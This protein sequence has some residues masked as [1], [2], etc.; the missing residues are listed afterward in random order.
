MLRSCLAS[1]VRCARAQPSCTQSPGHPSMSRESFGCRS[2]FPLSSLSSPSC[3]LVELVRVREGISD[4][5]QSIAT[6]NGC[7]AD[8]SVFV[9]AS[10]LP[11]F[12]FLM[13]QIISPQVGFS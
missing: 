4:V 13:A 9:R 6:P 5:P 10:A 12:T 11:F 3:G 2:S 1:A 7:L 8:V